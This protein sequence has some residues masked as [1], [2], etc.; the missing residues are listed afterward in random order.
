[1][2][3]HQGTSPLLLY[4]HIKLFHEQGGW[5]WGVDRNRGGVEVICGPLYK[6]N[7]SVWKTGS[8]EVYKQPH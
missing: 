4:L 7:Q 6:N 2:L 8:Y 1:M 5:G 3:S